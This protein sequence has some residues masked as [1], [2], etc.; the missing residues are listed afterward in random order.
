MEAL[1]WSD[2]PTPLTLLLGYFSA[3][4]IGCAS[5]RRNVTD[6]AN[7]GTDLRYQRHMR[8]S[9]LDETCDDGNTDTETCPMV[10]RTTLCDATCQKCRANLV[11][12]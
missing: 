1:C 11:L 12:W 5:Q 7:G 10:K 4:Q 8:N 2:L 3:L 6:A 9:Q